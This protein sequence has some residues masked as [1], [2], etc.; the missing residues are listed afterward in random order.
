MIQVHIISSVWF[1][2]KPVLPTRCR[3]RSR[4]PLVMCL[5]QLF[6]HCSNLRCSRG[7][8]SRAGSYAKVMGSQDA[9]NILLQLL[10]IVRLL[11]SCF[12]LLVGLGCWG[13]DWFPA[14]TFCLLR[15]RSA[16]FGI[17]ALAVSWDSL[18][19]WRCCWQVE[20]PKLPSIGELTAVVAWSL[21][22]I[23]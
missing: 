5:P 18:I 11:F 19:P 2:S 12:F 10:D 20:V 9:T 6:V 23:H 15:R 21:V 14:A 1:R 16:S 8:G 7:G 4:E 3:E 22:D 17:L 13:L